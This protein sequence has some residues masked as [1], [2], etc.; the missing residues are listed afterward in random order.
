M[1]LPNPA[2]KAQSA[3]KFKTP[4]TILALILREMETTYGQSPGGYIW[5]IIQ[6]ALG[7]ALLSF[8]FSLAFRSPSIG[9]NFPV[10]YATGML[11]FTLYNETANKTAQ[12]LRFSRQ[13]LQYPGVRYSDAI[14]AR[15]LLNLLTH[16]LVFYVV[17]TGI[18][19]MY[20]L[21]VFLDI[22]AILISLCMVAVL[23]LGIGCLNCVLMSMFPIWRQFWAVLTTPMFILS[24]ILF[25]FEVVPAIYRD[26]LWYNPLV[27][28]VGL[29]RRGFYPTYDAT[30][31]SIPYVFGVALVTLVLGLAFLKRYHRDILNL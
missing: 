9:T 5:A 23:G 16:L 11:P 26:Y 2:A 10:F 12:A 27:H 6:P 19:Y 29:M 20:D 14:I 15:F 17:M 8:V 4:R 1:T 31:V 22:P 18:H 30:Y 3:R 13:L 28:V 7:I 24:T 25:T 21:A